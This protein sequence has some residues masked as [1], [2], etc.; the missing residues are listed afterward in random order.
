[1]GVTRRGVAVLLT[2]VVVLTNAACGRLISPLQS[3]VTAEPTPVPPTATQIAA[4]QTQPAVT[5]VP[6][7]QVPSTA[8]ILPTPGPSFTPGPSPT[9]D[10]QQTSE[11]VYATITA[12][13][14]TPTYPPTSTPRPFRTPIGAGP[15][16]SSVPPAQ[17]TVVNGMLVQMISQQVIPGGSAVLTIKARPAD[18]C[19]LRID[20]STAS[21]KREEAIPGTATH[22]T[23]RDGVVAWIWTVD[24]NE[25]AGI[26][27]LVVDCAS[28][29]RAQIKMTVTR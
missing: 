20:R 22:P 24:Q 25:P 4:T 15:E 8:T 10:T 18:V 16:Q 13:A 26:M 7:T 14:A 11:S 28:A 17:S 1:M 23:G 27:T 21:D 9:P 5:P 12:L 3:A 2:C 6:A 29:G 19:T